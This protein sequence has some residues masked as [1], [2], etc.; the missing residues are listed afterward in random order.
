MPELRQRQPRIKDEGHR[1][2]VGR[3]SCCIC[4]RSPCE[5]AHIRF[6]GETGGK[7][8]PGMGRKPDDSLVVPLCREHHS[9]QHKIGERKFWEKY[10]IDPHVVAR[11]LYR[12]SRDHMMCE[13]IVEVT[14]RKLWQRRMEGLMVDIAPALPLI[15]LPPP[16]TN[17]EHQHQFPLEWYF[18]P[19]PKR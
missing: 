11:Y 8:N 17:Q 3:L 12:Y 9:E 2:R 7:Q 1:K 10:G 6:S 4:G 15:Q 18:T 14:W 16:E 13:K 19:K 5:A